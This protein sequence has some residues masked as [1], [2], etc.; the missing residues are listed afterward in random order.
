M[1]R[2]I[3]AGCAAARAG[4]VGQSSVAS[5]AACA[6]LA[7]LKST[8]HFSSGLPRDSSVRSVADSLWT[9]SATSAGSGKYITTQPA[10]NGARSGTSTIWRACPSITVIAPAPPWRAASEAS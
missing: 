9:S 7:W 4:S 6:V 5:S 8:D 2:S 10:S 3:I 1:R